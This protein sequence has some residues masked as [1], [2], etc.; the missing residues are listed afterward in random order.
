MSKHTGYSRLTIPNDP[1]YV[2]IA[3]MYVGEVAKVVGFADTEREGLEL[4][5]N[6]AVEN[7]IQHAFEPGERTTFDIM[8]DRIPGG[9]KVRI[10]DK[11][12][13]F[14][15]G[16]LSRSASEND[17]AATRDPVSGIPLMKKMVDEVSFHNL[18]R[19]G[20]E[21][22]LV[23]YLSTGN[24]SDYFD[25]SELEPYPQPTNVRTIPTR[26][27]PVTVRLM[28]RTEAAEVAR[29]IYQA[30]GYSYFYEQMYYPDRVV[31]LNESGTLISAVAMTGNGEM[32]G[33]A[34]L[35][36]ADDR[37][38][39]AEIAQAVVKP[40]F[41]GQGILTQMTRFLIAEGRLRGMAG[42]FL[43]TVTSHTFSQRVGMR[44][45]FRHCGFILGYAPA[46]VKFKGITESSSQ[47]ETF[48][49]EYLYLAKPIRLTIYP[50]PKHD[51]FVSRLYKN[52][53]VSPQIAVPEHFRPGFAESDISV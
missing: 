6:E 45:G 41:R 24:V 9:L 53:G 22:H 19:E 39:S 14:D 10:R 52:L 17:V 20:K 7:V 29:C 16:P 44:H 30:Y 28:K 12:L 27:V 13:P 42:V 15:P 5:V 47:R 48:E 34:A 23:K 40:E 43:G 35:L 49:L 32:A 36:R 18:G 1:G 37:T 46:D 3:G 50:P 25:E 51:L 11:G 26:R 2:A 31:E 21:T 8:C 38:P 33:H 4:A